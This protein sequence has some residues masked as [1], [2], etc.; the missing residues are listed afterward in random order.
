MAAVIHVAGVDLG[1]CGFRHRRHSMTDQRILG[2]DPG[3]SGGFA[4][5]DETGKLLRCG[6]FPTHTVKKNGKAST[7]L[8]GATL[9]ALI[10]STMATKAYVEAVSSRPRQA[11]QFQFGINTGLIHGILHAHR[12]SFSLV[13]PAAWKSTYG[14]KR[15][16][17]ETKRDK[18]NEARE[19]AA[20]LYP[21]HEA[22]FARVKDDGVAEATLIALYG[23]FLT[24]NN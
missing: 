1:H 13:A 19:I 15:L 5:V 8:D 23:L 10:G 16:E 12:V 24:I 6:V 9:A 17:E 4:L 2:I 22:K 3:L 21:E 20:R 11:G 14:I 7:Q 18:K